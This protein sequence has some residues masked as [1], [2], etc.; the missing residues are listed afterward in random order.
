MTYISASSLPLAFF[1]AAVLK[2]LWGVMNLLQFVIFMQLWLISVPYKAKTFIQALKY[3]AFFEFI[4]TDWFKD[5]VK[6]LVGIEKLEDDG[7]SCGIQEEGGLKDQCKES[8]PVTNMGAML[9]IG[10]LIIVIACLLVFVLLLT[11][12]CKCKCLLTGYE[13]F[14]KKFIYNFILRYVLQSTLKI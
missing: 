3:F 5:F 9:P 8:D 11:M 2:Y 4:P 14:K 1:F 12:C 6:S 10:I 7:D 13:K